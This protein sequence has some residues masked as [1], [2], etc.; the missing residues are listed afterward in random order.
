M[1]MD[2]TQQKYY[3]LGIKALTIIEREFPKP[4][5]Y[6]SLLSMNITVLTIITSILSA[7]KK[8]AQAKQKYI[9]H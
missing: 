5:N 6:R 9:I 3:D 2:K 4:D 1:K 7:I 8:T